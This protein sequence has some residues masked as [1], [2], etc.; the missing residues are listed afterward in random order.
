M[1]IAGIISDGFVHY[2]DHMVPFCTLYG[3]P[4]LISDRNM[5]EIANRNYPKHTIT[6]IDPLELS[7]HYLEAHFDVIVTTEKTKRCELEAFTKTLTVIHLPHGHSDKGLINPECDPFP[8][9]AM[10]LAYGQAMSDKLTIPYIY[11]GNFRLRYFQTYGPSSPLKL[12]LRKTTILYAPTYNDRDRGS[13]FFTHLTEILT[14]LPTDCQLLIKFHPYLYQEHLP[15][16]IAMTAPALAHPDIH[17][18]EESPLIYP[19]LSQTDIYLGDY[20]SI[21]YDFL[22]FDRPLFFLDPSGLNPPPAIHQCGRVIPDGAPIYP[23]IME[24]TGEELSAV[25][26]NLYHKTFTSS[27]ESDLKSLKISIKPANF[28]TC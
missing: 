28:H 13:S 20:S 3:I 8:K 5:V 12:D 9:Q 2:L 19:Y 15:E 26:Q 17:I 21:G 24:Y 16:L 27:Y 10:T 18:I 7:Y 25:R 23:Y 1:R 22:T 4:L 11:V 14:T 6:Y